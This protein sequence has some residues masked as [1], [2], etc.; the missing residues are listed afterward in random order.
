MTSDTAKGSPVRRAVTGQAADGK[1][2]IT[3]DVEIAPIETPLLPGAQ[4]YSLWGADGPVKLP[5]D[6]AEPPFRTWFPPDG[7]FRFELIMLPPEGLPA[8][9]GIDRKQALAET[10]EKLPGLIGAMD[11]HHPGMHQT[12]TVDLIYVTQGACMLVLDDETEIALKAGDVLIQNGS[13]HAWRNP[14]A[15]PCGL[16]TVSLGVKREG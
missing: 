2:L 13:R 6:G 16:L 4:F 3:S 15:E 1:P 9:A 12:D 7:G 5:N 11:P 10:E 14:H 8:P